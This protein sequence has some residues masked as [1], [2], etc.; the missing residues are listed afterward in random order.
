MLHASVKPSACL[1]VIGLT[2][3]GDMT[4]EEARKKIAERVKQYDAEELR[5]M[6]HQAG[7]VGDIVLRPEEFDG[8][9]HV[10]FLS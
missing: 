6:Y 5:R 8:T 4:E 7:L 10:G 1:K 2:S 3:D 9:E